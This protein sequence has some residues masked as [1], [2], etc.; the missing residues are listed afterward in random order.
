M[1][2]IHPDGSSFEFDAV[3]GGSLLTSDTVTTHPVED[4]AA[5]ADHVDRG[6]LVVTLS[7]LTTESPLKKGVTTGPER[8]AEALEFLGRARGQRLTLLTEDDRFGQIDG[9]VITRGVGTIR[10]L[11]DLPLDL[12]LVQVRTATAQLVQ[13]QQDQREAAEFDEP[14][15]AGEQS[16][17]A[18]GSAADGEDTSL[19]HGL[20]FG[21]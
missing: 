12:E 19:L 8:V 9:L 13:V 6:P 3:L 21:G 7:G 18:S 5:V 11:R 1:I 17:G 14:A 10:A 15:D 20:L 16:T 2:L 4:G